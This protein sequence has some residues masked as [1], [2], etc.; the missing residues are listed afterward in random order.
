MGDECSLVGHS[1]IEV[2][3]ASASNVMMVNRKFGLVPEHKVEWCKPS[4]SMNA[5][6]INHAIFGK[7]AFTV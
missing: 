6:V 1:G 4:R 2:L 3:V 7:M 5:G